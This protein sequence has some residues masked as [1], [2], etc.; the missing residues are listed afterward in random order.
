ML[1]PLVVHSM[2]DC[3]N[4]ADD[5]HVPD[6]VTTGRFLHVLL[7]MLLAHLVVGA[8]LAP[9]E[10][11]PERLHAIGVRPT[12]NMLVDVNPRWTRAAARAFRTG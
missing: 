11:R 1:E 9:I 2:N 6:V 8:E 3:P 12:A 10:L 4:Y 7:Q 5:I